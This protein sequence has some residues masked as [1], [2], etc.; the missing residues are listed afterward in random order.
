MNVMI[1]SIA[2]VIDTI[3]INQMR[4]VAIIPLTTICDLITKCNFIKWN[5]VKY[6]KIEE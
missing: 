4:P 2:I 6:Y 1:I 3:D 5:C